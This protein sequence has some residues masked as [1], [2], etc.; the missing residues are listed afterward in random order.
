MGRFIGK[1]PIGFAG[2]DVNLY[3]YVGN[4]PVNWIDPIGLAKYTAILNFKSGG[5]IP[6][7]GV[8]WGS[9]RTDCAD[10]KYYQGIL[11]AYFAGAT[12]GL[13]VSSTVFTATFSGNSPG[14]GNLKTLKVFL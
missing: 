4:G 1:D 5:A 6:G 13:P 14:V 12:V 11:T 3:A 9:V 8:S 7:G 10:G 2:G